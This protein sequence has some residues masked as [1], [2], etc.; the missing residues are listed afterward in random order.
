MIGAPP[1]GAHPSTISRKD[2][3]TV[4]DWFRAMDEEAEKEKAM[5]GTL[6]GT[7]S[8][9]KTVRPVKSTRVNSN[10]EFF[11]KQAM[12]AV[13]RLKAE[14]NYFVGFTHDLTHEQYTEILC[15]VGEGKRSKLLSAEPE[16][17]RKAFEVAGE[18]DPRFVRPA[19]DG[20]RLFIS[21]D[22]HISDC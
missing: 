10:F 6:R 21:P 3:I 1:G 11:M 20:L 14:R 9:S 7:L 4:Y 22:G 19:Y 5:R 12:E 17:I 8:R 18:G 15:A 16:H 13:R 2:T